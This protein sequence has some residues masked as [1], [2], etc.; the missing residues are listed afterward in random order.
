[1]I[2]ELL[3]YLK[4][5]LLVVLQG[6]SP[7]R[8]LNICSKKNFYIWNLHNTTLGYEFCISLKDFRKMKAILRKTKT[9]LIIKK[10]YG[11]PF[12]L[13]KYRKRKTY[14]IS[15]LGFAT[16][17]YILSLF[18]WDIHIE[19]NY[20]YTEEMIIKYLEEEQIEHGVKKSEIDCDK[21]EKLLRN[22]FFD[23]TWVS[24]SLSGTRL[25]IKI[26]ENFDYLKVKEEMPPY[27]LIA[28]KDAVITSIITRTGTPLIKE[29]VVVE[30][31]DVMVSGTVEILNDF[32]ELLRNEYVNA[33]ADI[34]GK[35]I[36][37]YKDT[38]RM[39]S[40]KKV[41]TAMEKRAFFL[42]LFTKK[43]YLFAN[44][45]KYKYY[46]I[47]EE[48]N[49]LTLGKNFYLPF[50]YHRCY[51]KEYELIDFIYTEEEAINL[52]KDNL[53][54]YLEKLIEKGVQI[55]GNN[56]K[57]QIVNNNCV[58]SGQILTVEKLGIPEEI[59]IIERNES[60]DEFN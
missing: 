24:A 16:I 49:T 17:I 30:K 59:N 20:S 18:I 10:K 4:G 40:R 32:E 43:F 7:E 13:Y 28:Q 39:K 11:L 35:T 44:N 50:S 31:G 56:V 55:I 26:Q 51:Y 38:F 37:E 34:Y 9:K 23:I 2:E 12:F 27:D 25:I 52:A 5:Y 53:N 21:I 19:G 33:D 41:Y 3:K 48:E 45:H 36:F 29:G 1:M 14:F 47:Y 8:F 6:Y 22:E 58:V 57:I 42:T 46:D 15:I 54:Y 60:V